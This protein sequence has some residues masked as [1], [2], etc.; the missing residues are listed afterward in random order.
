MTPFRFFIKNSLTLFQPYVNQGGY[1]VPL[2]T[3]NNKIYNKYN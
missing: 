3:A 1:Q 2:A